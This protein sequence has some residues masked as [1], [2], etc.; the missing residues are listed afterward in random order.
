M[1]GV[2]V[3]TVKSAASGE[4]VQCTFLVIAACLD[5][6]PMPLYWREVTLLPY[7]ICSRHSVR[8]IFWQV[9]KHLFSIRPYVYDVELSGVISFVMV[10]HLLW[11]VS[12]ERRTTV[13]NRQTL[14]LFIY[15]QATCCNQMLTICV[16]IFPTNSK[17]ICRLWNMA[18]REEIND[19]VA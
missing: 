8:Y 6:F 14:R 1:N 9:G 15:G 11:L 3:L 18:Y 17:P 5:I 13:S 7:L 10:P 2:R 16:H 19:Y 4:W 12:W